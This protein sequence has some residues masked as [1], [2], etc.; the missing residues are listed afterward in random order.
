MDHSSNFEMRLRWLGCACFELDFGGITVVTDPWITANQRTDLTWEAVEHCDCIAL[1]HGHFDHILDIPALA[2]KFKP[3]I[4]CAE[5]TAVPLMKWADINPMGVYP[6][7]PN[8]ELDLDFVSIKA[9]FGRHGVLPGTVNERIESIKTHSVVGADPYLQELFFWG[10]V[11]YRNFLFTMP[12]G[13]KIL[14]WGN[15]LILPEQRNAIL[16]EAPD[17]WILQ[18]TD[19]RTPAIAAKLCAQMHCKAVI[20]HH[21][22]FPKDYRHISDALAEA[23]A[24]HAPQTQYILPAY[25]QWI[26]L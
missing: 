17:I 22:D 25:G 18:I 2:K 7:C 10:D 9:L 16:Q 19:S 23:L 12:D 4:L 21:T 20:P 1:T 26:S 13:T 5:N 3:R 8:L 6:M 14:F 15:P 24:Q 11:E